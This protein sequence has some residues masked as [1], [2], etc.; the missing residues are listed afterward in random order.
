MSMQPPDMHIPC[1]PHA[2][3]RQSGIGLI[4]VM[5]LLLLVAA[6][7]GA[8]AILLQAKQAPAQALTQEQ[9]L[10]WADEAIA[11]FAAAHSRLPCPAATPND[12]ED[13]DD[14][15]SKGWLPWR[16][17]V[18]ASGN[19]PQIG[20]VA[21]MVYRGDPANHLDLAAVGNAYQPAGLDGENRAIV[22]TKGTEGNP[23]VTREL[24]AINGLDLCRT[25]AL[26]TD[27][28][29][30]TTLANV[31]ARTG[32]PVNVAYGIAAAGPQA[33]AGGRLDER[34]A[35]TGLEAPWRE[36]DSG[37]DDRVRIRSFD[38]VGQ[39]LGCRQL[40]VATVGTTPTAGY[41][42]SLAAMDMLAAAVTMH[43]TLGALQEN[44]VGNTNAS[45]TAA[46]FAQAVS[47]A[48]I[49]LEAGQVTDAVS[50]MI[51][52][53]ASLV[54]AVA[55][56]IA[57]LGITC[58]EVPLKATAL[59]LSIASVATHSVSLAIKAAV[60]VPTAMALAKTIK[61]RD[62]AKQAAADKPANLQ[63]AIDELAC[64]LY[65]ID[66]PNLGR[67]PC[68]PRKE[69][70]PKRDAMGN[71]VFKR[72]ASGQ[73]MFD[74]KGAP[75]FEYEEVTIDDPPG[76]DEKRDEAKVRWEA[77]KHHTDLLFTH[78]IRPWDDT[79]LRSER[80]DE[81]QSMDMYGGRYKKDRWK[82]E[83]AGANS[84]EY[85]KR[86]EA[87]EDCV[88]VGSSQVP[89]PDNTTVTVKNGAYDRV[90]ITVFNWDLATT[91]AIA[92]RTLAERWAV[93]SRRVAEIDREV[94][95]LQK[96]WDQWFVGSDAI[97]KGMKEER[98]ADCAKDQSN[99]TNKQ[100]C[101]NAREG[102]TYIETC[103]RADGIDPATGSKRFVEETRPDATCKPRM[104]ENLANTRAEKQA[105]LNTRNATATAYSNAPAP[106]MRYPNAWFRQA[107]EIIED[108]DGNP[109]RYDW[110]TSNRIETYPYWNA[111]LDPPAWENRQRTLPYYAP[112]PYSGGG[113]PPLL[114][115]SNLEIYNK[116]TCRF[117]NGT[118]NLGWDN[119][120]RHGI[121]CQRYPYNRAYEDW[122]RAQEASGAAK[123]TYDDLS[124]EFENL[125]REYQAL[126]NTSL[127]GSGGAVTSPVSFGAEAALERAD[128]RGSVGPQPAQAT[129][130]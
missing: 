108:A 103:V 49:V 18:G 97:L 65:G 124:R 10:R 101:D 70:V 117:F 64:N 116:N 77:L 122:M 56:C 115:T 73:Q 109:I 44:N 4:Q 28:V 79:R 21:Y 7:L 121:Y 105:S 48:A 111:S 104:A 98:D 15:A 17:L 89:G 66:P 129:T 3:S 91:D 33:G 54:R 2:G 119:A 46:G 53:S 24:E 25:L 62:R 50:T 95:E 88:H 94:E 29:P 23:D 96:S 31:E 99:P 61:A 19:G 42:A 87:E 69:Q 9:E 30:S 22:V 72:N 58:A 123:Q 83:Y 16:S 90:K 1:H 92:K 6:M 57:S 67:N 27:A 118:W 63:D 60:L 55:T 39:M 34:N 8:G 128:A 126:L 112:E 75:L 32:V 41:D 110:L 85:D 78:R 35:T 107:I 81:G 84:G 76:M 93:A 120:Y 40:S 114:V 45:V 12:K 106:F 80:I 51:T 11:A 113:A 26:A 68:K 127:D 36:W 125:E 14:D 100:I 71:P 74:A 43:D 102:V 82:C 13:C 52:T 5:L 86:G 59:G 130:P 37:Y 47:I 38:A 20:P